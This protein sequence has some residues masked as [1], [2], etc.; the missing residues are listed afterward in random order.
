MLLLLP[1]THAPGLLYAWSSLCFRPPALATCVLGDGM[2]FTPCTV[3][4]KLNIE[5]CLS[6]QALAHMGAWSG[7]IISWRGSGR[8]RMKS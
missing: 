5:Y 3:S 2:L 1:E 7:C 8:G 6:C 4:R